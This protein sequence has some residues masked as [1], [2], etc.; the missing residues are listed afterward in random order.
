MIGAFL[1]EISKIEKI[2]N[3]EEPTIK[4]LTGNDIPRC[5]ECNLISS[6]K[7]NYKDNKPMINYECENGHKGNIL[8]EEYMN[9]Y[10]K[11]SLFKEKCGECNKNQKEVKD[12]F[13]YCF[14]CKKCLCSSCMI[15]HSIIDNHN[16]INILRYDSFCKIHSNTFCFY[17]VKCKIN[18]CIYC[19]PKHNSHD[20]IDLTELNYSE[21]SKKKLKEE[22]KNIEKKVQNLDEIKNNIILQIEQLKKSSEYEIKFINIL[23]FTYQYEENYHNLN[24]NIIQNLKNFEQIFKS[25]KIEIYEKIYKE[26]NKYISLFQ[27]K[28]FNSFKNNFKTLKYHTNWISLLS[29]LN[30]GRLISSSGDYTLN[31]Y[32]NN[33]FELQLSIK[34]H[35]SYI[36]AF[37]QLKDKRIISCSDDKTMKLIKLIGEDKYKLEQTLIGYTNSVIKVIEIKEN[38]LISVSY[39]KTMKIWKLNNENKF[40]C[41]N[42]ITFQKTNSMCNILKLNENEFVTSSREDKC[43]KFWNLNNYSNISTINNIEIEWTYQTMCL[44][45]DNILC[46]GGNY[47]KGFYLIKISTHQIIKNILGPKTIYSINKCL[48]GLFLCSII[49]ENGNNCLVKYKYEEQNLKKIVEKEKAHD[50][51]IYTCI[52]LNDGIIASGG[53]DNLIKLWED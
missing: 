40:E 14:K 25:N 36:R 3:E 39:D 16:I 15:N 6:L 19:K 53:K 41:I 18:L 30:D 50:N 12:D 51:Y 21:E 10:N 37:T 38:E 1:R 35:S 32:K 34:E 22:I 33:S 49:N 7:L 46:I 2:E 24:F 13:F 52:E 28:N 31:I 23:L 43:I 42:T 48:D 26:G 29:Q 4:N 45:E 47:S 8:L 5:V 11:Y 20:L 44:L 17:C 27:N 9:K